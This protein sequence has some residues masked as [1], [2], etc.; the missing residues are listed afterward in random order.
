MTRLLLA[1]LVLFAALPAS[2]FTLSEGGWQTPQGGR[3][4][5]GSAPIIRPNGEYLNASTPAPPLSIWVVNHDSSS[6]TKYQ[7]DG[8]IVGTY[9]IGANS[10]FCVFDGQNIWTASSNASSSA[11]KINASTGVVVGSYAL[12][13]NYV[14]AGAFDGTYVYTFGGTACMG[15]V[16]A[17]TG[18]V[19]GCIGAFPD[20]YNGVAY[21]G[22]NLWAPRVSSANIDVIRPS[23]GAVLHTYA[24]ADSAGWT[25]WYDGTYIWVPH[26]NSNKVSKVLQATGALVATFTTGGGPTGAV[27][28][29]TNLWVSTYSDGPVYKIRPSDGVQLAVAGSGADG[30]YG[31]S[32]DG[33]N[34]WG[35]NG[36]SNQTRV[37]R[38]SDAATIGSY[39]PGNRQW[40]VC[41]TKHTLPWFP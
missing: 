41:T 25:P 12:G 7:P 26:R 4:R 11:I 20:T 37:Y 34:I 15:K 33:T 28:D 8:T 2:A 38:V 40:F 21:D 32:F 29:G 16:L 13:Q 18:A 3:I 31:V 27:T 30:H 5:V 10:E 24:I 39:G 35:A 23:D 9:S 19:V 6:I 14:Y 17:A 36:Y 1:L 22:T